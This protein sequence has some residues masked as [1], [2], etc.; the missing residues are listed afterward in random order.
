MRI[1]LNIVGSVEMLDQ[2]QVYYQKNGILSTAFSCR[3]MA[4]C[5]ADCPSFTG[6]K[7]AYVGT[8]YEKRELPRLLF[9]SLDSGSG[10]KDNLERLPESVRRQEEIECDVAGLHEAK[11]WFRTH[12]L[13]WYILKRF[14]QG[15]GLGDVKHHF[16]HANSAK[17]CMNNPG[18]KK[19]N[20]ILFRNCGH[21]LAGELKILNPDIVVTQGKEAREAMNSLT[22]NYIKHIDNFASTVELQ[23]RNVFWLHT[24]HPSNY[25]KFNPQRN[26]NKA[27][28][29]ADG[30]VRYSQH[31]YEFI[32]GNA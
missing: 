3:H 22:S 9:L 17:C 5:S 2:L 30:W 4:E 29:I 31:I 23:G 25:G 11:H 6:P 20:A 28:Q 12:E 10:E 13:A 15:L 1:R 8:G 27:T 24:Y 16:A 14:R 32:R 21:Y 7:S 19:A 26:F 18:R